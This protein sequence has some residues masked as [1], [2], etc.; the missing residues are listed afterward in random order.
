MCRKV[1]FLVTFLVSPKKMHK[2]SKKLQGGR[3]TLD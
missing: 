2:K 1:A 3:T